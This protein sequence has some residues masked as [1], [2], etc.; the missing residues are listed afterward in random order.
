MDDDEIKKE[1]EKLAHVVYLWL[2]VVC[3]RVSRQSF[4][5]LCVGQVRNFPLEQTSQKG[6]VRGLKSVDP[7]ISVLHLIVFL[8]RRVASCPDDG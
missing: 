8:P 3:G 6:K 7:Q 2:F 1:Q 5:V 4:C